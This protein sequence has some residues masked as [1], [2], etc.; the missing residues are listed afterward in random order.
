M[1]VS[2]NGNKKIL[3]VASA[4]GHWIE[5]LRI[6]PA[7]DNC[8]VVFLSTDPGNSVEV[9]DYEFYQIANATRRSFW[10]LFR[11]FFQLVKIMRT[12][13][14]EIIIT[15][16]SAP[17]LM[18]LAVGKIFRTK[19]VW[20]QSIADVSELSMSGKMARYVSDLFLVQW[21]DLDSLKGLEYR[22]SIL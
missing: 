17:G 8:E 1:E 14:P 19:N 4:G 18:T 20:I 11:M 10:N 16:G 3:A 5:L 21:Q 22:G 15:T 7:F 13:R 12:I 2:L 9:E 6:R